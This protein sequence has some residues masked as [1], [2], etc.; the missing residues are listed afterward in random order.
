MKFLYSSRRFKI[1]FNTEIE[2]KVTIENWQRILFECCLTDFPSLA[3]EAFFHDSWRTVELIRI[4][5]G[6][7]T[8]HLKDNQCYTEKRRPF[9]NLRIR[10]RKATSSDCTCFLRPGIDVCV[11]SASQ[12]AECSDEE[13]EEPVSYILVCMDL[14]S[15]CY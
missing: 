12:D 9:S 14:F 7:M 13:N 8:M 2:Q 5:D 4:E 10:S 3:F 15:T 6:T 1:T 11:L